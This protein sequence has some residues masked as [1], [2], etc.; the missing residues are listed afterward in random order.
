MAAIY[1]PWSIFDNWWTSRWMVDSLAKAPASDANASG[2]AMWTDSLAVYE[3]QVMLVAA[4]LLAP[5]AA[6]V[7]AFVGQ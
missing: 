4:L 6:L 1:R 2:L 7:L 5:L 3:P